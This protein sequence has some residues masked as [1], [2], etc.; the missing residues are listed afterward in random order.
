M[1]NQ[2]HAIFEQDGDWVIGFC[3]EILGAFYS[4]ISS[5]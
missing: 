1:V 4:I 2:F 3:P 5:D